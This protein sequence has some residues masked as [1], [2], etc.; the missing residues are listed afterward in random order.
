M[1]ELD[2]RVATCFVSCG[3][4]NGTAFLVKSDRVLTARHCV[5]EAVEKSAPITLTF[6][7]RNAEE[8]DF[9][10]AATVL[11]DEAALDIC[12][13]ALNAIDSRIP[14][15]LSD[16]IPREGSN[17]E[18]FGFPEGKA[19]FGHRLNGEL[20]RTLPRP[21]AKVDVDL[22]VTPAVALD[23]YR[24]MSGGAVISSGQCFAMLRTKQNGSLAAISVKA[25]RSFLNANGIP[26][27]NAISAAS[28]VNLADRSEFQ[29]TLEK[30]VLSEHG[31]YHF[32]EGT[33][34]I[35]K[36]TF[37]RHFVPVH[38]A[39]VSLGAYC[40][41]DPTQ[42]ASVIARAQP[43]SL[44]DWLV[45]AISQHLTGV[46]APKRKRTFTE[47][48]EDLGQLFGG[49]SKHCQLHR[50]HAVLFIDGLKELQ[51]ADTALLSHFLGLFPKTLPPKVSIVFSAPNMTSLTGALAGRVLQH[52]ARSITP[53]S[54]TACQYYCVQMLKSERGTD[55][56]FI[57]DLCDRANGH[58]LY[59]NYLI[60]FA[61]DS[62]TL[63]LD[64]FPKL[65]GSIEHYY[66]VVWATMSNDESA[67]GLLS[68][69]SRLR[70]DLSFQ[71]VNKALTDSERAVFD[72]TVARLRHL[73]LRRDR[74]AIY[75]SS[76]REYVLTKTPHLDIAIHSRLGAFC[77]LHSDV[78]YCTRNRL[79][80]L[81]RGSQ[82]DVATG[83]TIC[84][85]AWVDS[86]V[87][88]LADPDSLIED[89]DAVVIAA[90]K[91]GR[92][93][94]VIRLLLL[95]QRISFRYDILFA[96][97]APLV[98]AALVSI[99]RPQEALSHVLRHEMLIMNTPDALKTAYVLIQRARFDEAARVL[100]LV[101]RRCINAYATEPMDIRE[102]VR[103]SVTH[104]FSALL[105]RLVGRE[106]QMPKIASI[107]RHAIKVITQN[108]TDEAFREDLITYV[109]G[110]GTGYFVT[111]CDSYVTSDELAQVYGDF[112]DDV[113]L[114]SIVE[115]I[116]NHLQY[117]EDYELPIQRTCIPSVLA[118]FERHF[119]AGA[120]IPAA[121]IDYV[122]NGIVR[123][124]A[125]RSLISAVA[126]KH[127]PTAPQIAKIRKE[128]GV[129]ADNSAF[130]QSG[131]RWRIKGFLDTANNYPLPNAVTSTSWEESL[132]LL[133]AFIFYS[134]GRARRALADGDKSL[135]Q[136]I[137]DR[138]AEVLFSRLAFSLDDRTKWDRSYGL[139]ETVV[140]FIYE[141]ATEIIVECFPDLVDRLLTSMHQRC[142]DQLGLYNEGYRDCIHRVV[143]YL[144]RGAL[145]D[146]TKSRLF[147]LLTTL[148]AFVIRGVENRH[149]LVPELLDLIKLLSKIG[150]EEEAAKTYE[151][152]LRFSMGPSWYKEDQIGLLTSALAEV[153]DHLGVAEH[154]P[155]VGG[156]LDRAA[157]E[158]TFQRFVRA[159]K[160]TFFGLL[161]A[162]GSFQIA[163]RY[164]W[165]QTC[166][167][168]PR[169]MSE[170]GSGRTDVPSR[171]R[172][173]RYPGGAIDEQ[174]SL[175]EFVKSAEDID[176]R[177]RW[178][179]LEITL[180]GEWRY[181]E[182]YARQFGDLCNAHSPTSDVG[183]EIAQRLH[184][185]LLEEVPK[186]YQS[187]FASELSGA[188]SEKWRVA[189]SSVLARFRDSKPTDPLPEPKVRSSQRQQRNATKASDDDDNDAL[190]MPGLMGRQS[191]L[192]TAKSQLAEAG[193]AL[194]LGNSSRATV[195]LLEALREIQDGGWSI[196]EQ[197]A[198]CSKEI[199]GL[200]KKSA[201]N[202]SDLI[203]KYSHL[204]A[205]ERYTA[206]WKI[207][208]HLSSLIG[209]LLSDDDRL[210]ILDHVLDHIGVMIG[211]A[212]EEVA[213]LEFMS[214][215][216]ST[217]VPS[218]EVFG[219]VTSFLEHPTWV[220]REKSAEILLWL[221]TTAETYVSA[222]SRIAFEMSDGMT[223][224]VMCGAFDILSEEHPLETWSIVGKSINVDDIATRCRHVLRLSVLLRICKRAADRGS[225]S[226][227]A[228]CERISAMFRVG[229]IQLAY[230]EDIELP[231]WAVCV[232]RE[233]KALG[234]LELVTREL[235]VEM[236]DILTASIA[237]YGIQEVFDLEHAVSD[238]FQVPEKWPL[239]RWE[240]RVRVALNC[241]L[242]N[243][244]PIGSIDHAS[245]ILSVSNPS[246][247]CRIRQ[248]TSRPPESLLWP[249]ISQAETYSTLL[250]DENSYFLHY[251][252]VC[253]G[254]DNTMHEVRVVAVIVPS[255][256]RTR[257]HFLPEMSAGFL[258]TERPA[259]DSLMPCETCHRV[260]PTFA[261]F[262][263]FTPAFP[264]SNV[265]S[266]AP[267]GA[268][269][270][271]RSS[272][273]LGR[274]DEYGYA[275]R[276]AQEG[277]LLSARK[278]ALSIPPDQ[279]LAWII[280]MDGE[281]KAMVDNVGNEL[282]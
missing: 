78:E 171:G 179:L 254:S 53:L 203:A 229:S 138:F 16:T 251:H 260:S 58:P 8:E 167:D 72:T 223:A 99:D 211:T 213:R 216:A 10:I 51:V 76:F 52:N 209:S 31:A 263:T 265:V 220:R 77:S 48:T 91:A 93:I 82:I 130:F 272:W 43:E 113:R 273:K 73:F 157:G 64:D 54:S 278:S 169:L 62:P 192:S 135:R 145:D 246:A 150:A 102:F 202:A 248:P 148:K 222:A 266:L 154:L 182:P 198:E 63:N 268:R 281:T 116:V 162:R 92:A 241:A 230:T 42:Q 184:S 173:N 35:G 81:L 95:Y 237:P 129:D 197:P 1:T 234:E 231:T 107:Q 86:S 24:G 132:E 218:D 259:L 240:A 207:A 2:L 126:V 32:L 168:L 71:D 189:L 140:P 147:T 261:Y 69:I 271:N 144:A 15:A 30:Q 134:D 249:S 103:I 55:A 47:M 66:D 204:I 181:F 232:E 143:R 279:K 20:A 201:A 275:G 17:W 174:E 121:H 12:I 131:I 45:A 60:R 274:S 191:A 196:W 194:L 122:L 80:H 38:K 50:E 133:G 41:L 245:A 56:S 257:S 26:V 79:Y 178:G 98:A 247:P 127:P 269:A 221:L 59:L 40:V 46:A 206:K 109:L 67:V 195:L 123:L 256:Q 153:P 112:P 118:D 155:T 205:S 151:D 214:E 212:S 13:L 250:E 228:A 119:Q 36:T 277:C 235:L 111:F 7:T 215:Q 39:L 163:R 25:L 186:D 120:E 183:A 161:G 96:Q 165:A 239:N 94:D 49:L 14:V 217:S 23:S 34:G 176:W 233:W 110:I 199:E 226:A 225:D 224:D 97:S 159:Q 177:L 227:T 19:S 87:L 276:P 187:R 164:Y 68:L 188:V 106:D 142:D 117:A 258:S 170:W 137:Q 3:T 128:N 208:R 114:D 100:E 5:I 125:S 280:E 57:N 70:Q 175:L 101:E 253:E 74:A 243:Y 88:S 28:V 84:D 61:N 21:I 160:A 108:I 75:H 139:P 267:E 104:V 152:V 18:S 238:T 141:L 65:A 11:A 210:T 255:E 264:S 105:E 9:S 156:Y 22:S 270:F 115:L 200:L 85:Q 158:M 29:V 27:E 190:T 193:Q 37:C 172:G 124:G 219:F 180:F 146:A 4:R 44:Y 242:F 136:S 83:V 149:E 89:I 90:S 244:L 166:G 262:G 33:H 6:S 236:T 282:F 185:I 252:G